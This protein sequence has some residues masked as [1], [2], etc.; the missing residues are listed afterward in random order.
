MQVNFQIF[1]QQDKFVLAQ[2]DD[3]QRKIQEIMLNFED[4]EGVEF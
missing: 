2:V 1:K 4:E 3:K